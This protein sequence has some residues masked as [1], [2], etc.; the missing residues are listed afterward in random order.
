[1]DKQQYQLRNIIIPKHIYG[2]NRL[3]RT[4]LLVYGFIHSYINPFF[5][6][7]EHLAQMFNVHEQTISTAMKQLEE[8]G[9]ITTTYSPKADGGKIRLS[10]IAHSERAKTLIGDKK[11]EAP[12]ERK[13]SDKVIKENNTKEIFE[14]EVQVVNNLTPSQKRHLKEMKK[15]AFGSRYQGG[16]SEKTQGQYPVKEKKGGNDYTDVV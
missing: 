6:G 15:K 3:N 7:N 2:D 5:F 14:E 11:S 9:Y 10:E 4:S 12:T 16:G 13:H 8:L 1:M